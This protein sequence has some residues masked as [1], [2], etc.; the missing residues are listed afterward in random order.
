M[1][2]ITWLLLCLF[3]CI[4]I[5]SAQ[6]T[7]VTGIVTSA[8]DGEPIIGATVMVKGTTTGTVTDFDGA[9][10][11]NA[12]TSATT[13]IVSYVGMASQ[14]VPIRPNVHVALQ[15]DTQ[16]LDEIVVVGYGT[17]RKKRRYQFY[18]TN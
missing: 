13:L 15:Q 7:R 9:F 14:E 2:K 18:F 16:N 17:Q 1:K 4:G 6:T 5:V 8:S 11:L 10:D 12:P 3:V